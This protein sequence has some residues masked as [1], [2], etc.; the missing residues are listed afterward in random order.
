MLCRRVSYAVVRLERMESPQ[1]ERSAAGIFI[2]RGGPPRVYAEFIVGL[3]SALAHCR[4]VRGVHRARRD[5]L[6][7]ETSS[8]KGVTDIPRMGLNLSGIVALPRK[9]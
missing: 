1:P 4:P 2:T 9:P 5:F 8:N 3:R 6:S 7:Y